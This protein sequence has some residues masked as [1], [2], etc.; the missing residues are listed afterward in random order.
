MSVPA[1]S[2]F[3]LSPCCRWPG[4]R[5]LRREADLFENLFLESFLTFLGAR[6]S[7][8]RRRGREN[9]ELKRWPWPARAAPRAWLV[10][11][12]SA[13]P[14]RASLRHSPNTGNSLSV[15]NCGRRSISSLL[16]ASW[17]SKAGSLTR[18]ILMSAQERWFSIPRQ[19]RSGAPPPRD[20]LLSRRG[21][22]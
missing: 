12:L 10:I 20:S 15:M 11:G 16:I 18:L 9:F 13:P 3:G 21:Q 22:F 17:P 7:A 5:S 1:A 8:G 2:W 4:N 14:G 19:S 6:R